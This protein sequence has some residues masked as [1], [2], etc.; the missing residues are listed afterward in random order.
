MENVGYGILVVAIEGAPGHTTKIVRKL[1]ET[2]P[3]VDITLCSSFP[4]SCF[5]EDVTAYLKDFFLISTVYRGKLRK[6][7]CLQRLLDV[8]CVVKQF[9]QLSKNSHFDIVNIHFAQYYMYFA[10]PFLRKMSKRLV[11]RPWGSDI[12]R[13]H[14]KKKKR[15]LAKLYNSADYI[16]TGIEDNVGAALANNMGVNS[17][18][19]VPLGWGSEEVDYINSHLQEMSRDE[20]KARLGLEG[21]YVIACGYNAYRAQCHELIIR[22]LAEKISQL[23]TNYTLLF[24]VN[25]GSSVSEE[26][27]TYIGYLKSLCFELNLNAVFSENYLGPADLF[28]QRRAADMV[29]HIQTTDEGNL[30][31][32]EFLLCGAKIVHGNWIRY[33]YFDRYQPRCYFPVEEPEDV[34]VVVVNAIQSPEI[35]VNQELLAECRGKGWN[36]VMKRWNKFFVSILEIS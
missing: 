12:L 31:L 19:F 30:S 16:M 34:G 1:K 6:V 5:P 14:G 29:V 25:Y 35:V 33:S 7:K 13:L 2:N 20:A 21:R 24:P 27:T 15:T 32:Q 11:L 10:L 28:V 18:K 3:L 4:L 22:S 23:P 36:E 8:G 9:Y 26:R 17:A